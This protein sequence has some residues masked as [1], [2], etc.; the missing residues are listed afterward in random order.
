MGDADLGE[1]HPRRGRRGGVRALGHR[2]RRQRLEREGAC[3]HYSSETVQ[4]LYVYNM[5]CSFFLF[6]F[7]VPVS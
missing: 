7:A 6:I 5:S 4:Q 2:R 3:R 1:A